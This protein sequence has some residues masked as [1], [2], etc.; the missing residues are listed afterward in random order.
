M[1]GQEKIFEALGGVD[2]RLLERS[3]RRVRRRSWAGWG[4]ALAA[5]LL[6]ALL[7]WRTERSA[8]PPDVTPEGPVDPVIPVQPWLEGEVHDLQMRTAADETETHFRIY[9]NQE[10]YYSYEQEGVYI[11]R[12]YQEPEGTPACRLEISHLPDTPVEQAAESI[13]ERLEGEYAQ[14]QALP[15]PPNG[16]FQVDE[17]QAYLFASDGVEWDDAQREVWLQPDGAGGTFVLESGYFLEATEGHGARFVDMMCSFAPESGPEG[18]SDALTELR[19]AGER[20][21]AAVF[22]DSLESVADLLTEDADMDGYGEDVS[23]WVSVASIDCVIR[24]GGIGVV[25]VKHRMG[26]EDS[27]TF[28]TIEFRLEEGRW[29]A[30]F[31]GLER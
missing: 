27:Y 2:E 14:A 10:S 22:A 11:I 15:G 16:W 31:A 4:A 5:C 30:Y 13:L 3:E 8:P 7:A 26:G 17:G 6:L 19:N 28:L 23:E 24:D 12:P 18:Q 1:S 20:L 29:L 21:M 9:V 25:S